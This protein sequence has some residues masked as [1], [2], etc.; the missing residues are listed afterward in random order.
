MSAQKAKDLL[1][2]LHDGSG[3]VTVAGLRA[4]RIAFNAQTVDMSDTESAGRWRH[5][6]A[7]AGLKRASLT[8][9]GIFKDA[10]S[11]ALV[12]EAFFD[13]AAPPW[14]VV[15][16]DFGTVEGPFQISN[17]EY[18]GEH[19]GELTFQIAVESAGELTF[20]AT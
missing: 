8:G 14:Q 12:R 1:L 20:G 19:D 5:L 10:A 7:G 9:S 16:P 15:I 2:K 13:G 17:L 3:F 6:L 4:R 18:G 11:D